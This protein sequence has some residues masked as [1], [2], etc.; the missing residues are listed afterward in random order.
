[1]KL[2]SW[3]VNGIRAVV[4][5]DF[6][7]I[8]KALDPDVLGLQETKAQDDQVREALFGLDGTAGYEVY[9]SSAVKKGY[10]GTA[11]LTKTTPL[12]V[13]LELGSKNWT[14]RAVY[15][16]QNSTPSFS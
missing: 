7:E 10:S 12:S 3:N 8:L 9:S 15:C 16:V 2:Y 4:K 13:K 1:M 14:K 6:G 11:I 5:K